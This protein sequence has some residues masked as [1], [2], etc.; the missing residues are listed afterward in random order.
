MFKLVIHE[1]FIIP[2]SF[3]TQWQFF[4]LS[5]FLG[6]RGDRIEWKERKIYI[7]KIEKRSQG[8]LNPWPLSLKPNR[9]PLLHQGSLY[10]GN[11]YY[12]LTE[13]KRVSGYLNGLAGWPETHPF[14]K[15]VITG[16]LKN[17]PI[18][19]RADSGVAITTTQIP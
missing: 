9:L 5:C 13:F 2:S 11:I 16:W 6:V 12:N 17:Y 10:N 15:Q 19:N 18:I 4:Y 3:Q 14:I 7:K 8:V 1:G